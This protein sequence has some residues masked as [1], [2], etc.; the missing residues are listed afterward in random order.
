[1]RPI[2]LS[3]AFS[4][5]RVR[6]GKL[7]LTEAYGSERRLLEYNPMNLDFE[8]VVVTN[9][10]GN[11]TI[12]AI[13]W[14][15]RNNIP[16]LML[17]FNGEL[18]SMLDMPI[19]NAKTRI[20]Q[21]E[22]YTKRRVAVAKQFIMGKLKHTEDF[23]IW[24]SDRYNIDMKRF[25]FPEAYT[26]LQ[27]A[28]SLKSIMGVEGITANAYWSE[29]SKV[30]HQSKFEVGNRDIGRTNRPMNAID[31]VNAL[32]NY[33]YTYLESLIQKCL[34]SNGLDPSIGFLHEIASG[35]RPLT[36]DF[37]EPYRFLVDW[38]MVRGLETNVFNK[39]EFSRDNLAFSIKIGKKA[40]EKLI[41]LIQESLSARVKYKSAEWQWYTLINDKTRE[42]SRDFKVDLSLPGF[43][44]ERTDKKDLREK[45]LK[46]SYA[47]WKKMG[48]SKG[49]LWYMK[50]NLDKGSFKL[51]DKSLEKLS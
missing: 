2:L 51:Y 32:L 7:V 34:I 29:M 31:E 47:E 45:I 12:Q 44:A 42:F 1:M 26:K 43:T 33:G 18:M 28:K 20:K 36:Y 17:N 11:I 22:A 4:D 50:H 19:T 24:L 23:L 21:Y 15:S 39:D 5:I 49:S 6:A 41:R 9:P 40:V 10:S 25:A 30:F 8:N 46:M 38:S 14:L 48:Y 27:E 13:Y 35:K 3:G 37:I 16:V